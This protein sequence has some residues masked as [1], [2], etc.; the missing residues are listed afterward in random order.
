MLQKMELVAKFETGALFGSIDA[1]VPNPS[2]PIQVLPISIN[3]SNI[4]DFTAPDQ[5]HLLGTNAQ[6]LTGDWRQYAKRSLSVNP[7][8]HAGN[9]PTQELGEALFQTPKWKG[10]T[11]FSAKLPEYKILGI[12][13]DRLIPGADKIECSYPDVHGVERT[14]HIP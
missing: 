10:F 13:V 2:R 8:P 6:E 7:S 1:V 12:F 14:I 9:A 5:A 11:S 3:L 4:A